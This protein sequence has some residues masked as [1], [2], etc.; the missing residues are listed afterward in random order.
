MSYPRK[1]RNFNAF[2]DGISYFGIVSAGKLPALKI[3][4]AAHRGS[5]MDAEMGVDMGMEAMKSE[6][7]FDEFRPE[8]IKKF[9][10]KERIVMRPAAMGEDDFEADTNI[11]T[12]GGRIIENNFDD[13]GAGSDSKLM[14]VMDVDFYQIEQNGETLVKIDVEN[15]VR[16]IG[17]FDQLASIRQAMGI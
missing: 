7:T 14:I 5:G 6:L 10:R 15:G 11:F 9:G 8:V 17:G 3:K 16:I 2:L 1:I 12:I 13:L 4:T